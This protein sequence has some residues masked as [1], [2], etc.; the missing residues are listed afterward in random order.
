MA[1]GQPHTNN[2]TALQKGTPHNIPS[3]DVNEILC[4]RSSY[5]NEQ[6]GLSTFIEVYK[7]T[8]EKITRMKLWPAVLISDGPPKHFFL[9]VARLSSHV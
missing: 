7:A 5:A 9:E 8:G 6:G 1:H 3:T 2:K 4:I